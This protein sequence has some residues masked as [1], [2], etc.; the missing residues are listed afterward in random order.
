MHSDGT[1]F[2]W[3]GDTAW[4]LFYRLQAKAQDGHDLDE[5]LADRAQRGFTVV[6]AVLVDELDYSRGLGCAQ[7]GATPF[8]DL[9]PQCP[10]EAYWEWVD[11]VVSRAEDHGIYL[12]LLPVWGNW[13]NEQN[14]FE[15]GSALAYGRFLGKRYRRRPNVIWMLGGD[16]TVDATQRVI[17]RAIAEGIGDDVGSSQLITFHP[18]GGRSSSETFHQEEWL[19]FNTYQSGHDFDAPTAW[20]LATTDGHAQPTKPTLNSEPGYEGI[21]VRF[22]QTSGNPRLT[23]HDVRKDAYRSL[24]A[25]SF[26][27]TYGHSSIWQMLRPGD[28]PVAGADPAVPWYAALHTPGAKQMSHVSRLIT[29]RPADRWPDEALVVEGVGSGPE[30]L[31]TTR[32]RNYAFVYFPGRMERRIR[33]AAL[34]GTSIR[35]HW[36]D[37]RTGLAHNAGVFS[38]HGVRSFVTPD[39]GDWVLVLDNKEAGYAPPGQV[40]VWDL[41]GR[42]P[43]R[44]QARGP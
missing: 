30:R 40:N 44:N 31:G 39:G 22:W 32:G 43:A 3:I 15:Q 28:A 23:D 8:H 10:V 9:D 27:H 42:L 26:G 35:C 33:M 16:R 21:P 6:Q 20:R 38:A 17:W 34:G 5:Y 29:S 36:F 24:F 25:G 2:L 12:V 7:N 18:H 13:V 41:Q 4:E 11:H 14:L 1:P 37:P 19:S